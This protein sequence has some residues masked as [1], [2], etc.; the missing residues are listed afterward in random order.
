VVYLSVCL[1]A[2][3]VGRRKVPG[4]RA[5]SERAEEREGRG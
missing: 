4:D 3:Q 2:G 5:V 1:G